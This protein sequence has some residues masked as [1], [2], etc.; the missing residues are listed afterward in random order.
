LVANIVW[1]GSG[2][3]VGI[4]GERALVEWAVKRQ[5][6]ERAIVNVSK[7]LMLV[8]GWLEVVEILLG[9]T[10]CGRVRGG[11]G[12]VVAHLIAVNSGSSCWAQ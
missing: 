11:G 12:G 4:A 3:I 7:R 8:Q 9:V 2:G 1:L 6:W 10:L 5:W